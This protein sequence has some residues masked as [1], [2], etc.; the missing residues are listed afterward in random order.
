MSG[1]LGLQQKGKSQLLRD[2]V[3][4]RET[5]TGW[6]L[7][8]LIDDLN[9]VITEWRNYYRYATRS[10]K[11]FAKHDWWLWWRLKAWLGKKYGGASGW[12]LPTM[13][14]TR[15]TRARR[16]AVGR[17]EVRPVRRRQAPALPGPR[18]THTEW[19]EQPRRNPP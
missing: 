11:E 5:P 10:G 7:A 3:K 2:K 17:Q 14:R 9:P 8:N 4:V 16:M 13:H 18:S 15:R 1:L 12:K 19:M 6:L